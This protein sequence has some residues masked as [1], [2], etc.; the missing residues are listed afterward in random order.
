[1]RILLSGILLFPFWLGGASQERNVEGAANGKIRVV[2]WEDLQCSDCAAFRRMM[3]QHLLP[4][5]GSKVAFE[6]RDFPLPKHNW[7]R[8]AAIAARYFDRLKPQLG[9]EFRRHVLAHLRETTLDNFEQRIR[10]FAASHGVDPDKA[11]AA[12]TD[13]SLAKLVDEDFREGVAR[14]IGRT[15]TVFVNGRPFIERFSVEEISK[16]IEEALAEADQ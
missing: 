16:A 13:G 15:P 2:V 10:D 5:Y 14:G 7:A 9:A 11:A 1:M 6:H 3:D 8:H 4:K 12:L